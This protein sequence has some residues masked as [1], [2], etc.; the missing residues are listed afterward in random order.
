LRKAIKIIRGFKRSHSHND[1]KYEGYLRKNSKLNK[2]KERSGQRAA[3][4]GQRAAG[5]G[6]ARQL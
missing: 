6:K 4:S 5:Q 1:E 3:G 2:E